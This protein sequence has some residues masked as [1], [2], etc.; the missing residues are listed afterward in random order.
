[1]GPRRPLVPLQVRLARED[2]VAPVHLT[3]PARR[4]GLGGHRALVVHLPRHVALVSRRSV[5]GGNQPPRWL[6]WLRGHKSA[7]PSAPCGHAP[8]S[9]VGSQFTAAHAYT[10]AYAGIVSNILQNFLRGGEGGAVAGGGET[11]GRR[12]KLATRRP[13]ASGI[14]AA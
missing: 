10:Y 5:A 11:R 13:R 6:G 7:S 8:C 3:R 4:I 1:M 2:L 9:L 12:I 14:D